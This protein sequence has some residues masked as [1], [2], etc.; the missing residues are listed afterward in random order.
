MA[1]WEETALWEGCVQGNWLLA[2][3]GGHLRFVA[4]DQ[5]TRKARLGRDTSPYPRP[6]MRAF[7]RANCPSE[8][9]R[10]R[11]AAVSEKEGAV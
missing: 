4:A 3:K 1:G 6:A 9:F 2:V 7:G 8:P 10:L 5:A 11:P